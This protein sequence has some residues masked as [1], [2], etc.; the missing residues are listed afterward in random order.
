MVKS[1]RISDEVHAKLQNIMQ[2]YSITSYGG[3]VNYAVNQLFLEEGESTVS[4]PDVD[5]VLKAELKIY[6]EQVDHYRLLELERAK[7]PQPIAGGVAL[8][9]SSVSAPPPPPSLNRPPKRP[10]SN[11]KAPNTG[12][13]KKDYIKEIGTVFN[14]EPMS[15]SEVIAI[16]KPKHAKTE[17]TQLNDN[18]E[19]KEPN[20][21]GE[22]INKQMKSLVKGLPKNE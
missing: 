22:Q 21:I 10:P 9:P 2:C 18:F 11:Y 14:G 17:V 19:P 5:S 13:L 12:N 8:Q 1:V 16:T 6:K 20:W 7:H 4:K 15:P 3:A